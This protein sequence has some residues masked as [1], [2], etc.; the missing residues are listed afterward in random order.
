VVTTCPPT[1]ELT[2]G[3][4]LCHVKSV[5]TG[6]RWV[7]VPFSDHC[8]PLTSSTAD[9]DTLLRSIAILGLNSRCRYTEIRPLR[10][11]PGASAGFSA[12]T[13]F[14]SHELP[15]TPRPDQ[16]FCRFSKDSI[17][18]KIGRAER[19]RVEYREGRSEALISEFY[20]LQRMTRRRHRLPSQPIGWFREMIRGLG[21]NVKVR[22]AFKDNKAIASII[23]LRFRDTM[24]YKYGCS[25]AQYHNLGGL[26]M[27]LWRA[28]EEAIGSGLRKVDFG[29]SDLDNE[30]LAIFKDRWGANRSLLTYWTSPSLPRSSRKLW[31][32]ALARRAFA[33]APSGL[34]NWSGR[35]YRHVG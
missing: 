31:A 22:V 24:V 26:P 28:I 19:E 18:R 6:S 30:G 7:S 11:S 9:T 27:L 33:H 4:A 8:E 13:Q 32:G 10:I 20:R 34:L 16:V 23:T 25:D 35:F 17:Q 15:L 21:E 2:D 1:A 14:L 29:R 12:S 5:L 3:V